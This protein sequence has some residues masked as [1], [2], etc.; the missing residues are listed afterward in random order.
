[1]GLEART[2]SSNNLLFNPNRETSDQR[3]FNSWDR[4]PF[5][6]DVV[7]PKQPSLIPAYNDIHHNFMICNYGSNMCIDNDD[8][9]AYYLNHHN[10]EV[11]GGHKS[12]FCGHNKFTYSSVVPYAQDY[13]NGLCGDFNYVVP[14]YVDGYYDNICVQGEFVPYLYFE[15][16]EAKDPL[17]YKTQLPI[18][19]DNKVYNSKQ[20]LFI[21]CQK[22][23]ISEEKW[24]SLG[25]DPG[26]RVY[27]IP[28]SSTIMRSTNCL[29]YFI[30]V[31][32]TNVA[33]FSDRP[34]CT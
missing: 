10:Y 18:M 17:K 1:M 6:T 21:M 9:S 5:L 29:G 33:S 31:S 30:N 26:T 28:N 22:T 12:D 14:G 24:Q 3:P 20:S 13:Q 8:G 7:D 2:R 32:I 19:H 16:C 15:P 34:F 25:L 27:P 23:P 11:Y 4:L